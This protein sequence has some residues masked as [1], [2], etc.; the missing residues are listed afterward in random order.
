MAFVMFSSTAL[1][2]L[3]AWGAVVACSTVH[4]QVLPPSRY[5]GDVTVVVRYVDPDL[6]DAL[7]RHAG[8]QAKGRVEACTFPNPIGGGLPMI[9]VRPNP[10][11]L[12]DRGYL[13][14]LEIHENAHAMGWSRDHEQ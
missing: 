10:A 7:C 3:I 8:V 9:S 12:S 13:A 5:Q 14:R 4:A 1:W 11:K 2:G 6:T